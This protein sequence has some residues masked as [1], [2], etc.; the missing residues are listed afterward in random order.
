MA[1]SQGGVAG[2]NPAA[3]FTSEGIV[4]NHTHWKARNMYD[5]EP[6][7]KI[8]ADLYKTLPMS[9]RRPKYFL[10]LTAFFL[11]SAGAVFGQSASK[12]YTQLKKE[13]TEVSKKGDKLGTQLGKTMNSLNAVSA[14]DPK[15]VSKAFNSFQKDA[16]GLQKALKEARDGMQS[17]RTKRDEYF[18]AWDKSSA[19]ITNPDLKKISDERRQKVKMEHTAL[20]EEAGQTGTK[21]D[22]FMAQLSDLRKFLGAD[23]NA[24][25]VAAAK[26]TIDGV[27]SSGN[28]L[29]TDVS[30]ISKKLMG[31][32]NGLS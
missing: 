18:A 28:A 15:N 25:S 13:L 9:P 24:S 29:S 14:A 10:C 4:M 1:Q 27:V 11:V 17:L 7:E 12:E 21:I 30:G 8:P 22:K 5:Q 6:L 20:S 2:A 26:P 3:Q 23:L 19:S 32:A 31:F 16:D